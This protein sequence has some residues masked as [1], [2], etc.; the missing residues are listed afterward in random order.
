MKRLKAEV[1]ETYII[2]V[3]LTPQSA[4]CLIGQLQLALRHPGNV[5]HAADAARWLIDG[6][7]VRLREGG[8]LAHAE[9]GE[10]G[11]DVVRES[12]GARKQ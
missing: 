12:A 4:L 9:L 5:G 1:D 2:P 8:F 7:L 3:T 10:A 6:L 11:E